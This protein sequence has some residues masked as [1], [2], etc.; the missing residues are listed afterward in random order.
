M[1][2]SMSPRSAFIKLL[3]ETRTLFDAGQ[4]SENL[5]LYAKNS[6][7]SRINQ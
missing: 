3:K 2:L 5:L 1:S 7:L 4:T 6:S